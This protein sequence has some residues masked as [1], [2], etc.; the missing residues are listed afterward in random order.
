[1]RDLACSRRRRPIRSRCSGGTSLHGLGNPSIP[2]R[3]PVC[4]SSTLSATAPY[5]TSCR[6]SNQLIGLLL[7][8]NLTLSANTRSHFLTTTGSL[9]CNSSRAGALRM[10]AQ[11]LGL[12][13][14]R[15]NV[16]LILDPRRR[17]AVGGTDPAHPALSKC[18]GGNSSLSVPPSLT[19]RLHSVGAFCVSDHCPS[20]LLGARARLRRCLPAPVC[21]APRNC[22]PGRARW[23]VPMRRAQRVVA[24]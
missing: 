16:P 8:Q 18:P 20:P 11:V 22:I 13:R 24:V 23:R 3:P 10:P 6:T 9:R 4:N 15:R 17:P 14:A 7:L 1:M 19:P 21:T 2:R 5:H 12:V